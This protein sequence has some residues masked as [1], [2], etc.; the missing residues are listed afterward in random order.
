[1]AELRAA[2]MGDDLQTYLE[3]DCLRVAAVEMLVR[4]SAYSRAGREMAY[5]HQDRIGVAVERVAYRV[6]LQ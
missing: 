4:N 5:W 6:V 2:E 3:L 1:M